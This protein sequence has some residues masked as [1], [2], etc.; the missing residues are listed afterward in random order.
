MPRESLVK[1]AGRL[2]RSGLRDPLW[3]TV[4]TLQERAR[5]LERQVRRGERTRES[6]QEEIRRLEVDVERLASQGTSS[7]RE[8]TLELENHNLRRRVAQLVQA[9]RLLGVTIPVPLERSF[10]TFNV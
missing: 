1:K 2:T 10:S 3:E 4:V 5:Y 6:L 8:R 7:I 9:L